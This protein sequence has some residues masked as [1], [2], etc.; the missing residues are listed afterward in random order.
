MVIV[1]VTML[2]GSSKL[3]KNV[4]AK[5]LYLTIPASVVDDSAFPFKNGERVTVRIE[6]ERLI[7]EKLTVEEPKEPRF[8]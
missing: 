1:I 6:Y 4:R 2:K 3:C 5:T 7:V 8:G